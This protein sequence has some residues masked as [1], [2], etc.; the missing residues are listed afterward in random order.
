MLN[1]P[2]SL[3]PSAQL[4][5]KKALNQL[6]VFPPCSGQGEFVIMLK[7][8]FHESLESD[9]S[10]RPSSLLIAGAVGFFTCS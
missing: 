6:Q 1:G 3:T 9:P 4:D 2:H 5:V 7:G 8:F 10:R